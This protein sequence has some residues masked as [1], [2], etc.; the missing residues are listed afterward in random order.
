MSDQLLLPPIPESAAPSVKA[1]RGLASVL[2]LSGALGLLLGVAGP[3]LITRYA[4]L[5][6]RATLAELPR[7]VGT[8]LGAALIAWFLAILLHELGHVIGGVSQ[9]FRFQ[10]LVVGPLSVDRDNHTDRLRIRLNRQ[11]QL[12]GGI[13]ACLPDS[14][15]RVM[16][17]MRVAVAGGPLASVIVAIGAALCWWQAP[18]GALGA[19]LFCTAL[20]SGAIGVATLVPLDMGSFVSDGKRFLQLGTHD[21]ASRRTVATLV[22]ALRD[23]AGVRHRDE[24]VSAILPLLEPADGSLSEIGAR[25]TAAAWLV[26]QGAPFEALA[27]LER[28]AVI[29]V[30]KPFYAAAAVAAETARL[31]AMVTRD[32]GAARTLLAP[33]AKA[34]KRAP[35]LV[36]LQTD[37]ALALAEGDGATAR[38]LATDAITLLRGLPIV[39]TGSGQWT[40]ARLQEIVDASAATA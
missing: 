10:L 30:G 4:T 3:W 36:L 13:A 9:G 32:A 22:R 37:A 40:L 18:A 2:L 39:H 6:F 11:L 12:A 21:A 8:N 27:H 38:R 33:H 29:S 19:T 25:C 16:E 14:D 34:M 24:P 26:D 23:R 17:R 35:K 1:T 20:M 31:V 7:D 15:V 5:H 28:A